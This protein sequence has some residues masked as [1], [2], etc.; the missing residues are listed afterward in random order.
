MQNAGSCGR[1]KRVVDEGANEGARRGGT[2]E[3]AGMDETVG[4][5][6]IRVAMEQKMKHNEIVKNVEQHE[7]R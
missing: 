2:G 3:S 6:G 1:G 4:E 5:I 7:K